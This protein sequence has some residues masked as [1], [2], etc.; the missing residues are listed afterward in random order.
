MISNKNLIERI[1]KLVSDIPKIYN[2]EP[3]KQATYYKSLVDEYNVIKRIFDGIDKHI[4][5]LNTDDIDNLD[6]HRKIDDIDNK[7]I[8][9]IELMGRI[10]LDRTLETI[11]KLYELRKQLD[12]D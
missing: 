7:Y 5:D 8:S 3:S 11:N 1:A 2:T 9:S 10:N 4:S 12:N 6:M